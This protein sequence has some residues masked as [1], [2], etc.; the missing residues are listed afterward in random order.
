MARNY[1]NIR[2]FHLAY[3]FAI[4]IYKITSFFPEA[5]RNNI[6]SQLRRASVSISLNIAEGSAK[7][8]NN[9]FLHYLNTA[10]ASG[11]EVEVLLNLSKDLNY[12]N[13][14]DYDL[15]AKLLDE[16]NAKVF[17]FVRDIEEKSTK[18]KKFFRKF[19]SKE[20]INFE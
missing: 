11:K 18:R 6:V 15:L 3:K 10:W 2:V 17:L 20:G 16:V 9:E 4:K 8:S 1:K 14:T 5:E 19:E 7:A 12:L 13:K